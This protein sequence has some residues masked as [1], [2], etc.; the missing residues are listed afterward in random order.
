MYYVIGDLTSINLDNLLIQLRPEVSLKKWYPF[1]IAAG[2]SSDVLD[3]YAKS[4]SP[5]DC[6]M[7]MLD[8]WLRNEK[9]KPTW[10][11]IA[12]ILK[13]I[14]L[15]KLACD[16]EMV[17]STGKYENSFTELIVFFSLMLINACH[18]TTQVNFQF[19]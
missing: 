14:G 7:E 10:R 2:I 16:I 19:K 3:S 1:G 8:Y 12:D 17:Y 11:D 18:T 13:S 9:S 4:C 15:Q 6:I 5:E